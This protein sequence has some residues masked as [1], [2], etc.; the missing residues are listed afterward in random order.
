MQEG[1]G[2]ERACCWVR[3]AW[4]QGEREELGESQREGLG[5]ERACCWARQESMQE[6]QTWITRSR[7]ARGKLWLAL[8][9]M[10]VSWN[11]R[12]RER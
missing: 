12:G 1:L 7:I 3:Q 4:M 5:E 11:P 8:G 9:E 10:V 6:E 2:G